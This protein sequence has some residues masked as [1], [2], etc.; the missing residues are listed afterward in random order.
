MAIPETTPEQ[1]VQ[2]AEDWHEVQEVID[3][4]KR[5]KDTQAELTRVKQQ[6][7]ESQENNDPEQVKSYLKD[8][9]FVSKEE[10]ERER[11]MNALLEYNPE[12]KKHAKAIETLAK[13]EG[14]AYEDIIEEY[15][16]W[17]KDKLVT[18]KTRWPM[19]DRPLETKQK[20]YK[21]LTPKEREEARKG[22]KTD[23]LVVG[24]T[25]S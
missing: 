6:K 13:A 12:L 22:R 8:L 16:F 4:E 10:I 20:S 23:S 7:Q 5:F 2:T 18:A 21:D 11:Q 14:K 15:W 1:E 17:S 25:I 3:W 24:K 9:W 19:W